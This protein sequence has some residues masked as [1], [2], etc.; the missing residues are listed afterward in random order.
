MK[1]SDDPLDKLLRRFLVQ[2]GKTI[3]ERRTANGWSQKRMARRCGI[4]LGELEALE[5]GEK[6]VTIR[7]L[8]SISLGLGRYSMADI[9]TEA[10]GRWLRDM[11]NLFQWCSL[12]DTHCDEVADVPKLPRRHSGE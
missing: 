9:M 12:R 11:G 6:N 2:L 8:L 5:R 1:P 7:V 10:E 4:S 3:K